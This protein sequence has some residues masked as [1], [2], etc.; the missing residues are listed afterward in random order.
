[1][2]APEK[3][4]GGDAPARQIAIP[5]TPLRA[6]RAGLVTN[7][8]NPKAGAFWTSVFSAIYPAHAPLWL[9]AVTLGL[10]ACISGGWYTLLAFFF[11]TETVQRRYLRVR[12]AIDGLCGA[13]LVGLGVHLAA[14][15]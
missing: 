12:R 1:M 11:A 6:Y 2:T 9:A 15:R 5:A 3:A 8:T 7:L 14:S 10:V 13:L 4:P